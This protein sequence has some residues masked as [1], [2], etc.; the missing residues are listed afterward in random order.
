M[1][2]NRMRNVYIIDTLTIVDVQEIIKI[3]GKVI[4]LTKLLFIE[5]ITN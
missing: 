4:E 2:V 5:D 3:G 1:E